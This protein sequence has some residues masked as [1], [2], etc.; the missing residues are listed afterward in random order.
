MEEELSKFGRAGVEWEAFRPEDCTTSEVVCHVFRKFISISQGWVSKDM[1]RYSKA[2][3]GGSCGDELS[4]DSWCDE[5]DRYQLLPLGGG[6]FGRCRSARLRWCLYD[7]SKW[8]KWVGVSLVARRGEVGV[9]SVD[10]GVL[11]VSY[12]ESREVSG[13]VCW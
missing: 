1:W 5:V 12:V 3:E 11:G 8:S 7:T 4:G 13:Y 2:D 6:W 10:W 9:G